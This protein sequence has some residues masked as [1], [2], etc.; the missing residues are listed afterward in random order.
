M[1]GEFLRKCIPLWDEFE[2]QLK[3]RYIELLL[4]GSLYKINRF[5]RGASKIYNELGW[6][7]WQTGNGAGA[8]WTARFEEYFFDSRY[9]SFQWLFHDFKGMDEKLEDSIKSLPEPIRKNLTSSFHAVR[10]QAAEECYRLTIAPVLAERKQKILEQLWVLEEELSFPTPY[11]LTLRLEKDT[12]KIPLEFRSRFRKKHDGG[13]GLEGFA[14]AINGRKYTDVKSLW[15]EDGEELSHNV[16]LGKDAY[17]EGV[18]RT[19]AQVPTFDFGDREWDSRVLS[20]LMFDGRENHLVVMR[21]G[22]RIAS[23]AFYESL[24]SADARLKPYFERLGW[25]TA[26]VRWTSI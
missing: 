14:Y 3:Q 1:T 8:Q 2:T 12:L 6:T 15:A 25:P 11:E 21:G 16:S 24:L 13:R 5:D 18:L 20:F 17:G 10:R 19:Y 7:Y 23:L 4:S 22:Y 26:G 9:F